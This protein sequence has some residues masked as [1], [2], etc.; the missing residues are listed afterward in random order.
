MAD[1]RQQVPDLTTVA[2]A[3]NAD[4]LEL[5]VRL[6]NG[7]YGSRK[8]TVASFV[9]IVEQLTRA[10]K[11]YFETE[12][13]L[14]S[15]YPTGEGGWYAIVGATDTVWVWDIDTDTWSDSGNGGVV[16]S[17]NGQTGTVVL[18]AS[19]I[20]YNTTVGLTA[21][22]VNAAIDELKTYVDTQV[23]GTPSGLFINEI[24]KGTHT[25]TVGTNT[26]TFDSPF[27]DNNYV[28]MFSGGAGEGIDED[29]ATLY[30][31]RIEFEA[32]GAGTVRYLM[33]KS[34]PTSTT[35][36]DD[37]AI[38][39]NV[40]GEIAAIAQKATPVVGDW[41][42]IEDSADSNNKKSINIGDLP[43]LAGAGTVTN[44]DIQSTKLTPSGGPITT[45]GSISVEP[46]EVTSTFVSGDL[47][48]GVLS[49]NH[50]F[51]VQYIN[52][53][54]VYDSNDI[55]INHANYDYTAT[56]TNNGQIEFYQPITGTWRYILRA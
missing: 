32:L 54:V 3:Q 16:L 36:T 18:T 33:I 49:I 8:I 30:S 37:D 46:K 47:S 45:A 14:N 17:V 31:D 5:T 13:A 21:V 50:A 48:G 27:S 44:V 39:D 26:I 55:L 43:T 29:N 2:T 51:G 28:P 7:V 22:N 15:T 6:G 42:I 4:L 53:V 41:M 40:A 38:H 56:D 52:S 35:F 34:T 19:D 25:V 11:G 1:I 24:R 23:A 9:E 20:D 12:A 10:N